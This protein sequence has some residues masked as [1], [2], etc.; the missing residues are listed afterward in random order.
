M[1]IYDIL[2]FL[3]NSSSISRENLMMI[4]ELLSYISELKYIK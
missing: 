2:L 1:S 3:G 4:D